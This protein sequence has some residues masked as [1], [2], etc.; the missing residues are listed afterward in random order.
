MV[1]IDKN[2]KMV[3]KLSK[4]CI[5]KFHV[6]STISFHISFPPLPDSLDLDVLTDFKQNFEIKEIILLVDSLINCQYASFLTQCFYT[7]S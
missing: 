5:S 3:E 7:E 2:L 4:T 6:S 1:Y